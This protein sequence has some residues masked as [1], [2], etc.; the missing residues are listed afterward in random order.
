MTVQALGYLG[1]RAKDL[2]DWGSYGSNLLG[3]QRTGMSLEEI[4]L[5]LTTSDSARSPEPESA[6]A[7]PAETSSTT[8]V[9]S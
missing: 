2:G 6:P 7:A 1:I 5:H 8:E 4:F 3:L 9:S